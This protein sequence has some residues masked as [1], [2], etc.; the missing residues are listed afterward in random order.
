MDRPNAARPRLRGALTDIALNAAIPLLLYRLAKRYL[1]ASEVG[2]LTCA[3]AFPLG[4]SAWDVTR[5]Q[6]LDPVAMVVLLGIL[7]SGAGV[8]LGGTPRLLLLRESL[9][10]GP[11]AS[12][13]LPPSSCRGR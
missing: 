13:A 12:P 11:W 1:A 4:K 9:F 3:A 8:L 5:R 2:A 7:G 6:R 10:T